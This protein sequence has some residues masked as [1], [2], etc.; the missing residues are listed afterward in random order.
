MATQSSFDVTTGVD[1]QE[2]DNAIN[3]AL[4]EISQRYDFKG[5]HCKIDFD[6]AKATIQLE[7]DDAF[8]MDALLEVLKAKMIKRKVPLKNLQI[9]ENEPAGPSR[10]KRTISLTQGISGDIARKIVKA[11]KAEKFKKVQIAIQA[12]QLRVSAG[13]KDSLQAV[14]AFLRGQDWGIELSFGNYR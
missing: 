3:Q 12:D 4:K 7:A 2:V 1:L 14:M 6:R 9:P 10:V 11:F 8:R 13:S 5:T